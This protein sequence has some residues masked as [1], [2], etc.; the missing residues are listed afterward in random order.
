[1]ALISRPREAYWYRLTGPVRD[2]RLEVETYGTVTVH[3]TCD[4]QTGYSQQ[5][6]WFRDPRHCISRGHRSAV[7]LELLLASVEKRAVKEIVLDKPIDRDEDRL[8]ELEALAKFSR[9]RVRKGPLDAQR[10]LEIM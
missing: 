1:M 7:W 3:Y 2:S 5:E 4:P 9:K 8:R 10:S 6:R